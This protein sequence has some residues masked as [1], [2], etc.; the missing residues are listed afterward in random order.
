MAN[1]IKKLFSKF[2]SKPIQGGY[3]FTSDDTVK[4]DSVPE[5]LAN[6]EPVYKS[7]ALYKFN[8]DAGLFELVGFR[9]T[10]KGNTSVTLRC[11]KSAD[12]FT[13]SKNLFNLL[14]KKHT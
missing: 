4:V 6:G 9:R 11:N 10:D 2:S 12:T 13:I 8:D 3:G 14:F 7:S 5:Q 1:F